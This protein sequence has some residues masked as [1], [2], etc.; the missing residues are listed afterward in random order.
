MPPPC[1]G[2]SKVIHTFGPNHGAVTCESCKLMIGDAKLWSCG[3]LLSGRYIIRRL[4]R[5]KK[6][7]CEDMEK[8]CCCLPGKCAGVVIAKA[9]RGE[10]VK[11]VCSPGRGV[12]GGFEVGESITQLY[13]CQSIV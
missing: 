1:V 13:E 2:W 5:Y 9:I 11:R 4:V 7:L 10:D 12:Y 8:G 6:P 3:V